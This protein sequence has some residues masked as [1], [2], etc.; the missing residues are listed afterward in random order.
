MGAIP[1]PGRKP[2]TSH[3]QKEAAECNTQNTHMH[4]CTYPSHA[5]EDG[6]VFHQ[7]KPEEDAI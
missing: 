7:K 6:P 3:H 2:R 5:E 4:V 1:L